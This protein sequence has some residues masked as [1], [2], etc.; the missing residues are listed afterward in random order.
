MKSK[1]CN[2]TYRKRKNRISRAPWLRDRP[3]DER[4]N[5]HAEKLV[6]TNQ[7]KSVVFFT[8][9]PHRGKDYGFLALLKLLRPDLFD[10]ARPAAS[11]LQNL[12][13][14]FI[15]NNKQNIVDMSG[16][17]IFKPVRVSSETYL[18]TDKEKRFYE[19]PTEFI[20][21][22]KAYASSLSA[23]EGRAVKLVL[24]EMQKH[25]ETILKLATNLKLMEDETASK[26]FAGTTAN[27]SR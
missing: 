9:T 16:E 14:V 13:E 27:R 12:R 5:G 10:P 7:V 26:M 3:N 21:T 23:Q 22:G 2:E 19:L 1:A 24:I 4:R 8:G 20:V 15:R 11:Q 6:K 25:E 17:K 18:Y